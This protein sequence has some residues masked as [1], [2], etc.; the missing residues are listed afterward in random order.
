M[1]CDNSNPNTSTLSEN[2]KLISTRARVN[3]GLPDH[4]LAARSVGPVLAQFLKK[5]DRI[6]S[7][8]Y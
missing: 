2:L 5:T 7:Q 3:E 8:F 1:C 4:W 6:G